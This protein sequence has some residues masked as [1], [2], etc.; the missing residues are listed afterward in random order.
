MS[1]DIKSVGI[2][3]FRHVGHAKVGEFAKENDL[4]PPCGAPVVLDERFFDEAE[5]VTMFMLD[6]HLMIEL[7]HGM[8]DREAGSPEFA[9][10]V[11]WI[12]G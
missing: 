6:A 10:Q 1:E 11:C 9:H 3:D 8:E 2:P 12:R 7:A 4:P 5:G